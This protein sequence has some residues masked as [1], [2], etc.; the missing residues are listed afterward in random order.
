MTSFNLIEEPW[1]PC[2]MRDGALEPLG[3]REVLTRAPHISEIRG[4]SPLVV[5]ALHRLLL[6]VLYRNFPIESPG[7]WADLW[8]RQA[9]DTNV[10]GDYLERW[11]GRF[12]LFDTERPFYQVAGLDPAKG[13][14]VA[15]LMFHADNNPVLFSHLSTSAPPELSPAEATRLLTGFMAFDV[16]GT[17]TSEHGQESANAA[18]LNK[19]AVVLPRGGS[20][21]ETLMLNMCRYV[22]EEGDPWSFDRNQDLPAWER[23][24]VIR[25]EDRIPGGYID[26]LTWQS[27]RIRLQPE[28]TEDGTTVVKSV[29]I[30]KGNQFPAGFTLHRKETMLAFSRNQKARPDQDPW[31]VVTFS[32]NRAL[33]RDSHT[34]MHSVQEDSQQ[35]EV[36]NWVAELAA[37]NVLPS[38]AVL[39]I[40]VFGLNSTQSK[41]FFWRHER[42][43]LP[44]R[45]L[46]EPA[47]ADSLRTA[48]ELTERTARAL[49]AI[50]KQM[51]QAVLAPD[52][53][54]PDSKQVNA[55]VDHLGAEPAYWSR[56]EGPFKLFIQEL[57]QDRNEYGEY[58]DRTLPAWK[59]TLQNTLWAAFQE[60]T[61]GMERSH[62]TLRA[63][64][65][66]EQSIWAT[67]RRL[68]ITTVES[69]DAATELQ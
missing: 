52:Q 59:T 60:A 47:L 69:E 51:A 38:A 28:T 13:G 32:R 26:L 25:P 23:D 63:M 9:W 34:L 53:R 33:W 50:V 61:M 55:L 16:G 65:A 31:P 48:L 29:V 42:L 19:G 46:E 57:A 2:T 45:Y 36:L 8:R 41:I 68:L 17:K 30:M 40:D 56:L 54:K 10:L 12:D 14:S 20:L 6:A 64:A 66:A 7:H 49:A 15:R 35:P 24:E 21:F 4:D 67:I 27:R 43:P 11:R 44:V 62:R 58:G 5:A 3:V 39:P 18:P 1:I 37:E 22:P